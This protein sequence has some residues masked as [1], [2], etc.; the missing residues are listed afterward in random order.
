MNT[1]NAT[2][3]EVLSENENGNAVVWL[4]LN[5]DNHPF[6]I[7]H[8]FYVGFLGDLYRIQFLIK[9]T[10][11]INIDDLKGKSVR[12][13][14]NGEVRN[15]LIAIGSPSKNRFVDLKGDEFPVSER[16]IYW[17]YKLRELFTIH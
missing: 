9:N 11:A 16:R 8:K 13:I 2:I 12:V 5:C 3:M 6:P 7:Y 1:I 17:R 14:D 10:K 4:R 15:Y